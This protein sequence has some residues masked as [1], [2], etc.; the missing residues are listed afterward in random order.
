[1]KNIFDRKQKYLN[2][3]K[4]L[5]SN[6][7][8]RNII[9]MIENGPRRTTVLLHCGFDHAQCC[10]YLEYLVSLQAGTISKK[11]GR[12]WDKNILQISKQY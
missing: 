1:M 4:N 9:H 5:S 12:N 2:R 7:S 3:T 6:S 11:Y 10:L 8:L